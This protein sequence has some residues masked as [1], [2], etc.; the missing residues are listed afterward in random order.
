MQLTGLALRTSVTPHRT[1]DQVG[2]PTLYNGS[3]AT[4]TMGH[5]TPQCTAHL[6]RQISR[7]SGAVLLLKTAFLSRKKAHFFNTIFILEDTFILTFIHIYTQ[8]TRDY[9]NCPPEIEKQ[10]STEVHTSTK[11]RTPIFRSGWV[12][13]DYVLAV[14]QCKYNWLN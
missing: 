13:K 9:K 11:V 12:G 6:V 4:H 14:E 5:V 2:D 8:F 7:K 3:R 1:S 10:S